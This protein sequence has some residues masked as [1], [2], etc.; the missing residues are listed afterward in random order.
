VSRG[1]LI[2]AARD[3]GG[4]AAVA[5]VARSAIDV[6]GFAVEVFARGKAVA[7]FE[8]AGLPVYALDAVGSAPERLEALVGRPDV[9]AVVTGTSLRQ[10]YEAAL[11][12]GA[13]RVGVPS[14]A[15]LDHWCNYGERF[16][17]RAPFD[18]LPDAIGVMDEAARE[19]MVAAGAPADRLR[20]TGQPYFDDLASRAG[21]LD[22]ITLRAELGVDAD[23]PIVVFAS[24]PQ[25]KYFG[26]GLGY[27]EE[28][29]L[30]AVA[31][32]VSRI[33]PDALLCVKLHPLEPDDAHAERAHDL[34]LDVR[35]IRAWPSTRLIL[36]ANVVCGMTSVFLLEAAVLGRPALSIRPGG[37]ADDHFLAH[38]SDLITS[39]LDSDDVE[40]A[41][42]QSF[43]GVGI[44]SPG[45]PIGDGAIDAVLGLI[46]EL[47]RRPTGVPA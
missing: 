17:D 31:D 38:H 26:A 21:D 14:V 44:H 46:S 4:A 41:P 42:A 11:W 27:D 34:P 2:V 1:R 37:D 6:A 43:E 22:T 16:T 29:S 33:C 3:A 39:V 47:G 5:P 25:R 18:S 32:A 24:E 45:S 10:D 19:A 36:A 20:V 23:R 30:M 9:C 12:A 28:S 8:H 40:A 7:M 15:V 35:V 13:A